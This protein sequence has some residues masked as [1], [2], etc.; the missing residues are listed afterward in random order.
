MLVEIFMSSL[1][2]AFHNGCVTAGC[3][4]LA[5]LNKNTSWVEVGEPSSPRVPVGS[6][7]RWLPGSVQQVGLL[8]S[9]MWNFRV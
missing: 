8:S 2:F 7:E 9:V 6:W 5:E 4:A 3:N 1:D